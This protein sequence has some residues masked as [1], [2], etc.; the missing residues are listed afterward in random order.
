M[1]CYYMDVTK[2]TDQELLLLHN[3]LEYDVSKYH[4]FQL[5][6]K[7]QLNSAYGYLGNQYSRFYNTSMA[8]A[9]TISGQMTIQWIAEKVNQF[10]NKIA[11]T[12]YVD[13]V[14]GSDT[15][16]IYITVNNI[17]QKY[18]S[19]KTT[20]ELID[21]V[22]DM[23]NEVIHPFIK[24]SLDS[25]AV[26][27]N[28]DENRIVMGREV[29][30]NRGAWTAKK[31]YLLNV[32]DKEG[33]RYEKPKQKIVGLETNRSSTPEVVRKQLKKCI[34]IILNG[35]ENELKKEVK[36]FKTEFMKMPY[37]NIAFP[38]GVNNLDE[39]SDSDTIYKK[40][41]P[42]NVKA[43]LL[44]NYYIKKL[45]LQMKYPLIQEGEKIKFMHLKQPN[46][47]AG[48]HGK[49]CV[50]GFITTLPKEF[51]L[52][53]YIDKETQYE[54]SFFDPLNAI[55]TAIKWN[56]SETTNIESLF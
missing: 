53:K 19:E 38:R 46:P 14:I 11:N 18:A 51:G 56:L 25:L 30:A 12:T 5:C 39:Y 28:A 24:K 48:I 42:M 36:K 20:Q 8:E 37:N 4:N 7:I 21:Y 31:R 17:I 33:V 16:S 34:G 22:N 47:V 43:A 9:I 2:L 23:S 44:Y 40:G 41:T 13:Y 6:R 45:N 27:L 3:D 35:N 10:L 52:D 29:I 1:L 54:K 49:D 50:I 32:W 15:D 55:A 26:D